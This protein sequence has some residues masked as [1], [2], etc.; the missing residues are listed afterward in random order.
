VRHSLADSATRLWT[1]ITQ[2]RL[3]EA[4]KVLALRKAT[5]MLRVSERHA[6]V[7]SVCVGSGERR[8]LRLGV[9]RSVASELRMR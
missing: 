9:Q 1:Q 8:R 5:R 3:S 2:R 6:Y 7:G 4:Q